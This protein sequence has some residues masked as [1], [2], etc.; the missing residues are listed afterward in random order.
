MAAVKFGSGFFVYYILENRLE[1][2]RAVIFLG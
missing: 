2:I 1:Q